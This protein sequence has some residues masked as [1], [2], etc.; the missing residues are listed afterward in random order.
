MDHNIYIDAD[1]AR[2]TYK[3]NIRKDKKHLISGIITGIIL[4]LLLLACI[5]GVSRVTSG[6]HS[7]FSATVKAISANSINDPAYVLTKSEAA[8]DGRWDKV[9]KSVEAALT[10]LYESYCKGKTEYAEAVNVVNAFSQLKSAASLT[11]KTR[12]DIDKIEQGRVAFA[13]AKDLKIDGDIVGALTAYLSVGEDDTLN[14][15]E[16]MKKAK[17]IEVDARSGISYNVNE[18]LCKFDIEGA[19]GYVATLAEKL[20]DSDFIESEQNR[21]EAYYTEQTDLVTFNGPVE[22]LFTHCLIAYPELCY[23]SPSM[24]ASLDEDCITPSELTKILNALYEK[25]Y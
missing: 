3:K 7:S 18:Y 5:L 13:S 21:I 17:E 10:Q 24:T 23:S 2:V 12:S 9:E 19:R 14:Y 6:A 15:K 20:G 25:D 8:L 22:H 16:A 1:K 4:V 11:E